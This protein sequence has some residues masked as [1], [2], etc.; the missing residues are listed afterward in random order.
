MGN[1][2]VYT[3]FWVKL[4]LLLENA[5]KLNF[6]GPLTN[7]KFEPS[8]KAHTHSDPIIN[9]PHNR[10]KNCILI[11]H[12]MLWTLSCR[13]KLSHCM[14]ARIWLPVAFQKNSR[15]THQ[16][17]L[18]SSP[19]SFSLQNYIGFSLLTSGLESFGLKS[20]PSVRPWTEAYCTK[21]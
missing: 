19:I 18:K 4:L 5:L 8:P 21:F 11:Y 10:S 1:F 20:T 13:Q 6:W 2:K 7:W 15:H 14:K 3:T 9:K 12:G 16:N 17:L